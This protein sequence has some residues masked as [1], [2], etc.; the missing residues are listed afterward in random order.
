MTIVAS[1]NGDSIFILDGAG[2]SA[3]ESPQLVLK[4]V[5]KVDLNIPFQAVQRFSLA[6]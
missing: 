1:M 3:N 6:Q 5:V 2:R 4:W